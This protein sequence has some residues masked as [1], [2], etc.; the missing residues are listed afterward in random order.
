MLPPSD[1]LEVSTWYEGRFRDHG[2]AYGLPDDRVLERDSHFLW[3]KTAF[4]HV[5]PDSGR[6]IGFGIS[7]GT[8]VDADR[9]NGYRLGGF[10]PLTS[11][12]PR[13]IPGYY[14]GEITARR[15][16]LVTGQYGLPI[17]RD[18]HFLI[19]LLGATALVAYVP[20]LEQQ[21]AS[22]SG[23]ELGL[24]YDSLAHAWNLLVGYG[25]GI[26]ALRGGT[27]GAHSIGLALQYDLLARHRPAPPAALAPLP[28]F[29]H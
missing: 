6:R 18:R 24:Q 25:Y 27:H 13:N 20:G 10:L 5:L 19:N 4:I 11:D 17:D 8:S 1:A 21:G 22:N 28:V 12:F 15:F 2:G 9:L 29:E 7:A 3:I 14:Y 16:V 23:V 26:N